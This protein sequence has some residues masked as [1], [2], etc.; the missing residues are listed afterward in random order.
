[1]EVLAQIS[2]GW[3][4]YRSYG[5]V[6]TFSRTLHRFGLASCPHSLEIYVSELDRQTKNDGDSQFACR[7]IFPG[8]LKKTEFAEGLQEKEWMRMQ[9]E[10]GSRLFVSMHR[11]LAVSVEWI[12]PYGAE[13]GHIKRH[14]ALAKGIAY[15]HAALTA[16][17]Y[18]NKGLGSFLKQYVLEQFK[19]EGFRLGM[20]AV[21]IE[22]DDAKRWH[23]RTGFSRWGEVTYLKLNGRDYW[24]TRLTSVGRRYPD[25]LE[26][27]R[28]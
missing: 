24:W 15:M 22:N 23:R 16:P 2:R 12:N 3:K 5:A 10:Q 20:L 26:N 28:I 14:V 1:M 9:F 8:D 18:R 19:K 4:C 7:E 17:A 21:F 11:D 27:E 25:L 13:L 6:E